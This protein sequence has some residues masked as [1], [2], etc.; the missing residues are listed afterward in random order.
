MKRIRP[1][2]KPA[3][4]LVVV[5]FFVVAATARAEKP[6][7]FP[8]AIAA[9][10]IWTDG[11]SFPVIVDVSNSGTATVFF[12]G[13]G[14]LKRVHLHITEQDT[15]SANG[16]SVV[17]IPYTFNMELGF[18]SGGNQTEQVAT[19]VAGKARLPDGGLFIA[20]GQIDFAAQGFPQ[21]SFSPDSG[22]VQNLD[23]LCAALAP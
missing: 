15:F 11:C 17:G 12:D 3:L 22:T 16:K 20:A 8:F 1:G 4:S 2:W 23:G 13:S 21:F 14:A 6:V 10:N 9:T 18:D 5:T 19:G 7:V